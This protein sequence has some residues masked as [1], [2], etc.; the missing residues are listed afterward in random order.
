MHWLEHRR[1]KLARLAPEQFC[2]CLHTRIA[3]IDKDGPRKATGMLAKILPRI[4]VED[5]NVAYR[6][7]DHERRFVGVSCCCC[8]SVMSELALRQRTFI[9][10]ACSFE[11]ERDL[12]AA[13]NLSHLAA[14]SAVPAYGEQCCE[15]AR[16][17]EVKRARG[18]EPDDELA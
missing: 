15:A 4:G 5:P 10:G 9:C 13:G 17:S 11:A 2:G 3:N 7:F 16:K 8:R 14:S 18:Q 12:N 6:A 1:R